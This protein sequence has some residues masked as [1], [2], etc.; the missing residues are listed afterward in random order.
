ML[1]SLAASP[2]SDSVFCTI[3]VGYLG[4]NGVC[5][6]LAVV[7]VSLGQRKQSTSRS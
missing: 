1:P 5:P 4:R 2:Q 6:C 7:P 3:L